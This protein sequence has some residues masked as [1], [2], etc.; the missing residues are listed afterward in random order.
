MTSA[1]LG[2]RSRTTC[3]KSLSSLGVLLLSSI[4]SSP[5]TN[6]V[7]T[8]WRFLGHRRPET[9]KKMILVFRLRWRLILVAAK[10][11]TASSARRRRRYGG[12]VAG[13]PRHR[14]ATVLGTTSERDAFSARRTSAPDGL[15]IDL[16]GIGTLS[17]PVSAA[18]ARQLIAIAR[19]AQYGL[20]EQTL[21]DARVRHTWEVPKSRVTIDKQWRR[22]TLA[23]MLAVLRDDLGL[24]QGSRLKATLHSV[25]VY[26]PGQFFVPHQDS[27]KSDAMVG[28]LSVILPDPRRAAHW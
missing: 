3:R 6:C 5:A 25:L 2:Q 27:E 12:R 24:P 26:A 19:P 21:T 28:T 9:V 22:Q 18:Q 11:P 15:R 4:S 17:V 14:L 1:R 20:G 7:T 23:P 13:E 10:G 16:A 8:D